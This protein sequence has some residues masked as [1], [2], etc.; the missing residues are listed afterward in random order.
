M[1]RDT[2]D[3]A[4]AVRRYA[5]ERR[6]AAGPHPDFEEIVAYDRGEVDDGRRARIQEHLALCPEC[7][8]WLLDY[9][10]LDRAQPVVGG[11]TVSAAWQRER[12]TAWDEIQRR[13]GGLKETA[14]VRADEAGGAARG[15]LRR[16]EDP[17]DYRMA[18]FWATAALA[19]AC[20]ILSVL[21]W[22]A[23]VELEQPRPVEL[24]TLAPAGSGTL[25]GGAP[26][27]RV[28]VR[29]AAGHRM[30]LVLAYAGIGERDLFAAEIFPPTGEG[31]SRVVEV[32][33]HGDGTLAVEM[34]S[35]PTPGQYRIVL[36]ELGG[37]E[38]REVATYGLRIGVPEPEE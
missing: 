18:R 3:L 7:T 9:R 13:I 32:R 26:P 20:A 16:S 22:Q 4:D 11:D 15:P 33:R 31:P 1:T 25:R 38:P 10:E 37:S 8:R 30:V 14:P 34:G 17:T 12:G 28:V 5:A 21:L 23:R 27:D 19:A 35:D 24:V 36:Y 29:P 6:A 2:S